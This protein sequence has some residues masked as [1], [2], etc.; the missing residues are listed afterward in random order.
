MAREIP[1]RGH[2]P[3]PGYTRPS[4]FGWGRTRRVLRGLRVKIPRRVVIPLTAAEVSQFWSS[5]RT[6]RD[7]SLVALMLFNGLRS[8]ETLNL[9]LEDLRFAQSEIRVQGKGN[10]QRL[11]PLD[12]QTI[13]VIDCYLRVERPL[14][15][16]PFVFVV[17]KG[18]NR[19]NPLTP[20]GL[21]SLFRHHRRLSTVSK[22]NPHRFRHT[23]GADM[24]RAGISLPALMRLMGHSH[25]HTTMLY[26]Q[27]SP[28]DVWQRVLSR[29]TEPEPSATPGGSMSPMPLCELDRILQ[30]QLQIMAATL[31]PA[32]IKYYR[33]QANGFLRYLHRNYPELQAPGQLQRNPHMLGWLRSLAEE[34]PPLTNRSRRAALIC[35]RRLFDD[36]ADNGYPVREA[37]ILGQDLPPR[38]LYLPI[39]LSPEV[40]HLLDRELRQTDD[41]LANALLLIRATGMRVG[42]CL[43]LNRDS[44]RHL[45][46]NQWALHVPLGK[47]HNERWV[48]LDDE[49][50]KIFERILS[51]TGSRLN[52]IRPIPH[53]PCSCC[54]TAKQCPT[55]G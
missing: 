21:R 43:R 44:L 45:G 47:L 40:D 20:A 7:L 54:P 32:T 37:L 50:R 34:S 41:L 53:P 36:L 33:T 48:P 1:P 25:I 8:R 39:P 16:S 27:L 35:M 13:K 55:A 17:L 46:G 26:V 11:L 18:P 2:S 12:P 5:F 29:H 15:N 49:A 19:G 22:A 24:V 23:F 14:T 38:D 9:Q 6:Y 52:L 4:P 10:R 42:E 3:E 51:L 31:K 30:E 28:Q